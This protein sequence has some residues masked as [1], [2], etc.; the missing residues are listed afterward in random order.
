MTLPNRNRCF[1]AGIAF[2]A[3]ALVMVIVS[4]I[5]FHASFRDALNGSGSRAAGIIQ[6]IIA[7][8]LEPSAYVPFAATIGSVLYSLL[9]ILLIYNYFE[10]THSPEILYVGLFILSFVFESI[11]VMVPLKIYANLPNIYL[12][13][14]SRILFFGRYFGLFSLF[15]V[16]ICTAGLNIQ[17]QENIVLICAATSLIFALGIPVDGLSW[18]TTLVMLNDFSSSF[19][20]IQVGVIVISIASFLVAAYTRGSREYIIIGAGAFMTYTGRN[21]F[22]TSDTWASLIPGFLILCFGSWLMC[23]RYH[24]L[25]L[26]L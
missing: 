23:N 13:N 2:S 5:V 8:F 7:R 3:A 10:K 17:K 26:W 25:Y 21:I 15:A 14:S 9:G 22:F 19:L 11:R 20:V 12:L 16:S 24:R 1:K 18:D 6:R 4:I